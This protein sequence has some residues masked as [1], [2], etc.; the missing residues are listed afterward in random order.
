MEI[1]L[2]QD[3][4]Q[5]LAYW[6]SIHQDKILGSVLNRVGSS[7]FNIDPYFLCDRDKN[8]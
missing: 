8:G 7:L 1:E 3:A 5:D 6:Q 2:T 4:R